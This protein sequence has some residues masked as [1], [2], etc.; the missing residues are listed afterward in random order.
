MSEEHPDNGEV[1][2]KLPRSRPGRPSARRV[3]AA[4]GAQATERQ[5]AAVGEGSSAPSRRRAKAKTPTA[6]GASGTRRVGRARQGASPSPAKSGATGSQQRAQP[7]PSAPR[8]GYDA[9]DDLA[10]EVAPPSSAELVA[11]LVEVAGEAAGE[12]ARAALGAGEGLL[13]RAGGLLGRR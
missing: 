1:L 4:A 6:A 7:R 2:G 5:T 12:L 10:A 9:P 11:S 8:Q 3:R 13:R